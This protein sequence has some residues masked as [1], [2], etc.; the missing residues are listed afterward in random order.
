MLRDPRN[1]SNLMLSQLKKRK[2]K[3]EKALGYRIHSKMNI[4]RSSVLHP[5]S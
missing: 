3:I 1:T 5:K 2:K 4:T